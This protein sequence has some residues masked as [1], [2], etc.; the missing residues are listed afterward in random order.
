MCARLVGLMDEAAQVAL[1]IKLGLVGEHI[2]AAEIFNTDENPETLR[3][4]F[5][6]LFTLSNFLASQ[7]TTYNPALR[8]QLFSKY[9]EFMPPTWEADAA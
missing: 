2:Q 8:G 5:Q 3:A 4:R 7:L 9:P 6:M 1:E